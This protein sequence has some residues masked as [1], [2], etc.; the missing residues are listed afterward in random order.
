MPKLPSRFILQSRGKDK[1]RN[2]TLF[3]RSWIGIPHEDLDV[4]FKVHER[5]GKALEAQGPEIG[6][7]LVKELMER[8]DSPLKTCTF[9]TNVKSVFLV[10]VNIIQLS[11]ERKIELL[12]AFISDSY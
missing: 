1:Q 7:S 2:C 3:G 9:S 10:V 4:V 6:F 5:A 12:F 8:S 11:T